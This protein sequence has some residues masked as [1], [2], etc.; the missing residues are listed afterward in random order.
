[1][2]TTQKRWRHTGTLHTWPFAAEWVHQT[3]GQVFWVDFC[4]WP[5][6]GCNADTPDAPQYQRKG[7]TFS[8]DTVESTDDAE[9]LAEGFLKW[10]GCN[11]VHW[12][13]EDQHCCSLAD[14]KSHYEALALVLRTAVGFMGD[15]YSF[16][17]MPEGEVLEPERVG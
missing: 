3:A 8:P 9:L 13:E 12:G 5:I 16:D 6:I 17:A 14:R 4:I 15:S 2:S 10:D 1:M 11:E 7:S